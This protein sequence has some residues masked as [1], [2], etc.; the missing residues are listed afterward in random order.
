MQYHLGMVY[1]KLH[2]KTDA[3]L[4]LKKAISLDPNSKGAKDASAE[5]AKL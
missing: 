5:L 4:H 2:D 3:Q 1:S